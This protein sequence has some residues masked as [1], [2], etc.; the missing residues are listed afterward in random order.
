MNLYYM[1]NIKLG[2]LRDT[3]IKNS[4][5]SNRVDKQIPI[6]WGYIIK[7]GRYVFYFMVERTYI[8]C[9]SATLYLLSH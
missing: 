2:Y 1:F 9:M 6:N 8:C 5:S 4:L 3:K 7:F